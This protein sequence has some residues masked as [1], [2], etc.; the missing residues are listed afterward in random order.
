MPEVNTKWAHPEAIEQGYEKDLKRFARRCQRACNELVIPEIDSIVSE[1]QRFRPDALDDT[2]SSQSG[3]WIDK[4]NSALRSALGSVLGNRFLSIFSGMRGPS[5]PDDVDVNGYGEQ[6]SRHNNRQFRKIIR[7]AYGEE[8]SKSEP[9]LDDLLRAWES[10]N[11]KLIRSIPERY[12]D[13]LQG[14]IVRAINE[15]QTSRQVQ[16]TIK[17]TYDQPVNRAALIADDQIGKLNAQITRHRQESV[18]IKEYRWRGVL[19]NRE[20]RVHVNREGEVF[21]WSKPPY[22]GHPGQ[23]VRC[24]CWAQPV[25]PPREE[26]NL[27]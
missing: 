10:E 9:W 17:S 19:D 2:E 4:L 21:K 6:V 15:G 23:P 16:R 12:I 22:D 3:T 14:V 1:A 24:R 18:G 8:V 20:R 5:S 7:K 27:S 13:D 25:M 26:V 11:L